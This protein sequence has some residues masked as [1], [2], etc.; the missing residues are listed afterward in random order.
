MMKDLK[1]HQR[2]LLDLVL[3][4]DGDMLDLIESLTDHELLRIIESW[5]EVRDHLKSMVDD[6]K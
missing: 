2:R 6:N 1:I 3:S 5:Q 4:C